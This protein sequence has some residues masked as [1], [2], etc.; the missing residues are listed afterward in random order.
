[1][2]HGVRVNLSPEEN[3]Y[4]RRLASMMIPVYAVVVLAI[5]AVATLTGHQRAGE[6]VAASTPPAAAVR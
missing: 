1:M 6:L 3:V 4:A 2:C 5:I